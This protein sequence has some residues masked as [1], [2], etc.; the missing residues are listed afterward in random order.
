MNRADS[1]CSIPCFGSPFCSIPCFGS[2]FCS[3]PCFGSPFFLIP[4][5]GSPFCLIPCFGSPFFSIPCFG[6]PFFSIPCFGSPFCSIPCFGSPFFSI[7]CFG[8]PFF[9]IP[10]FGSPF[11]SDV[12]AYGRC[13]MT[14]P[15]NHQNIKAAAISTFSPVGLPSSNGLRMH[16]CMCLWHW[17][18]T[19]WTDMLI[20][21]GSAYF[22]FIPYTHTHTFSYHLRTA[23]RWG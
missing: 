13:L 1:F 6:S 20:C 14:V 19:E 11:F 8:S 12:V 17:H 23:N 21:Q 3:I 18:S 10:C 22:K 16:V 7:P 9:S 5:F 15:N 2:P 4:C